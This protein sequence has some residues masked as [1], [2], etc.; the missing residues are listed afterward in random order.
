MEKQELTKKKM[1][2]YCCGDIFGGGAFTLVGMLY[3]NFLTDNMFLSGATV[4]IMMLIGKIWDSII[5]PFIGN[6]SEKASS[7][8]GKR[9]IF[10]FAAIFHICASFVA[11]WVPIVNAHVIVKA[12]YFTLAYMLFATSFS[13]TMVPYHA[14]LPELTDD[15]QKR[16]KTVSIRSIF[17]NCSSMISG[18]VPAILVSLG[19]SIFP[20][21]G[22]LFMGIAFGLFYTIPWIIVFRATKG[23]D[24]V[25]EVSEKNDDDIFKSFVKNAKTVLSNRSFR[26]MLGLYLLS[27]TAMDIFMAIFIYY[28]KWYMGVY[29]LESIKILFLGS[30]TGLLGIF[31][32]SEVCSIPVYT[33]LANIKGKRFAFMCS[34]ALW[35]IATLLLFVMAA[36]NRAL[37]FLIIPAV[38]MG[39]G[40]GG[41]A[42]LPW[43]MLPE[44]MD[45]EEL[46]SGK[47]KDGIYSGFLTFIRQLSQALALLIVGLYLDAI[48]YDIQGVFT[49]LGFDPI[50]GIDNKAL[51]DQDKIAIYAA[52]PQNMAIGIKYFTTFAPF[53]LLTGSFIVSC[54]YPIDNETYKLI[55]KEIKERNAKD[56]KD[57]ANLE[58]IT[59]KKITQLPGHL[60]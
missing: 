9:R 12:L 45:V 42:Y 3:M 31:M 20:G 23:I 30:Y 54:F 43:A 17:S 4:G 27:Y 48:D 24:T 38:L 51:T 14:M 41:V 46:I 58:K 57:I 6:I 52:V 8:L 1:L 49:N 33:K 60:K 2:G 32:V 50:K 19:S 13:L 29:G 10:F 16:N 36:P 11:L 40:A 26:V 55:K 7:K 44:T 35:S 53:V 56:P 22:H 39:F 34:T 25:N 28:V 15:L 18:L 47:K 21:C 5:D 37:I 59:G